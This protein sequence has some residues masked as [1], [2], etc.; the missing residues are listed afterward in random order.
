MTFDLFLAVNFQL[1]LTWRPKLEFEVSQ[2]SNMYVCINVW[3]N[4]MQ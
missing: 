1:M 2:Y 3:V 4:Y